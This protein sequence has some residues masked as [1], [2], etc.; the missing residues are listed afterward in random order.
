M[1]VA[2]IGGLLGSDWGWWRTV[3]ENLWIVRERLDRLDLPQ[4]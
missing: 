2:Y 1:R 4:D 3:T